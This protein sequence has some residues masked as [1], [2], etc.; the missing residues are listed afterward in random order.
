[1]PA[2]PWSPSSTG[3]AGPELELE[4][5]TPVMIP[6]ELCAAIAAELN[7]QRSPRAEVLRAHSLTEKAW[8]SIERKWAEVIDKEAAHGPSPL[9]MV[10]DAAYIAAV[11]RFRGR[12][13]P[14]EYARFVIAGERGHAND[15]L[16][17]LRIQ[18]AAMM[19]LKRVWAKKMAEDA[20]L[21]AQVNELLSTL[22]RP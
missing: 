1:M 11:E 18:R 9:L 5:S 22:R 12:V 15:G 7:E 6:L 19:R 4:P 17:E 21:R 13:T 10:Y 16:D 20:A 14:A 2:P 8:V 3:G